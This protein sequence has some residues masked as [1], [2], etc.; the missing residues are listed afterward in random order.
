MPTM[1]SNVE[2]SNVKNIKADI[3]PD[4]GSL[5]KKYGFKDGMKQINDKKIFQKPAKV[6]KD[7][8]KIKEIS[9]IETPIKIKEASK[10][11]KPSKTKEPIYYEPKKPKPVKMFHNKPITFFRVFN[12]FFFGGA[13]AGGI[14]GLL[15]LF[16]PGAII[17]LFVGA[18]F[19]MIIAPIYYLIKK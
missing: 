3:C 8:P 5:T 4:C 9:K 1:C 6:I 14:L 16:I 18:F 10:I 19:G 17:G 15:L 12:Y 2:C 11:E 13:L 7:P